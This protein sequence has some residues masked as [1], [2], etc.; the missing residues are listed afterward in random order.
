MANYRGG[1]LDEAADKSGNHGR[2]ITSKT[3]AITRCYGSTLLKLK[4]LLITQH[5]V[6]FI[7]T[8]EATKR[9]SDRRENGKLNV[10]M[11]QTV[12]VV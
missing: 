12:G 8:S 1:K 2:P 10:Q 7:N 5:E 6:P 4:F 3:L 11:P 9:S